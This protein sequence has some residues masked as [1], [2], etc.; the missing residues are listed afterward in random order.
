MRSP[1]SDRVCLDILNASITEKLRLFRSAVI[2]HPS[3]KDVQEQLLSAIYSAEPDALIF[4][5]GPT[6]V[7]KSTLRI[8]TVAKII[9]QS[10]PELEGDK[11]KIPAIGVEIPAPGPRPFEWGPSFRLLLDELQEPL[12]DRKRL[13]FARGGQSGIGDVDISPRL[14]YRATRK[15]SVN[16]Y[17]AAYENSLRHRR[18]A[19]V[20]L[21]DAH[22]IG[23]VSAPNMTKQ[24]D[25]V[26]SLA[27]RSGRPHVLL[28]TY[29]LLALR[30]LSDQGA[31]RSIDIHFGRYMPDAQGLKHF[32]ET[33]FNLCGKMPVPKVPS[34]QDHASYLYERSAG[35]IGLLK[36][37]MTRALYKALSNEARTVTLEDMEETTMSDAALSQIMNEMLQG[38]TTLRESGSLYTTVR[39]DF[40][41]LPGDPQEP[42]KREQA[43]PKQR[44]RSKTRVGHRRPARDPIGE[45]NAVAADTRT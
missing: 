19:A 4:L 30:N 9:E 27:S 38:E 2:A 15:P 22:Y 7:G 16:D 3:I 44:P 17:R 10:L 8:K 34:L 29:P 39:H 43:Q 13:E 18:P 23:K 6:H 24:L 42:R 41:V 31:S 33:V 21:D 36:K 32:E 35:C 37:W 45:K 25:F 20:L 28:G 1:K 11:E 40:F 26:K 12:I 5:F 14:P